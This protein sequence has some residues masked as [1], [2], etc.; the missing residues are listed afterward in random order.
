MANPF[1]SDTFQKTWKKAFIPSKAIES[2]NFIEGVNFYKSNFNLFYFNIGKNLTKGNSYIIRDFKDYKNKTLI[3]Y[4]VITGINNT[5]TTNNKIG[6]LKS[7]QYPGFLINIDHFNSVEEYLL[8]TF[9]KNTRMKMRKYTNRLNT[10]FNI[11]SKM[12]FG[13]IDKQEYDALFKHF[14]RLLEKRYSEKQITYNNMQTSEW[15]FYTDVAYPLILEKKASLFVIYDNNTPIAITYNYHTEDSLIDAITVFD[16]DYSKFNIGYVNNLKLINWCFENNIK[17]LDFSKGYFDYKKRMCT[18][19]Y[20]FEYHIIYDKSSIFSKIKAHSY[21]TFLEF[22]TYLRN[23]GFNS[24]FHEFTY[25]LKNNTPSKLSFD[26]EITELSNLPSNLILSKLDIKN[27]SE[28]EFL[29]RHINDFLYLVTK[30][31]KDI[32]LYKVN[33]MQHTYILESDTLIL[34]LKVEKP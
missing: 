2:F 28:Y 25:R 16:I 27:D 10:C 21:H 7:N 24:K 9:S 8:K 17:T 5:N 4:D 14:M 26:A 13:A 15:N 31:Y 33:D 34:Q 18:S 32:E 30:T 11:S 1:S 3:V 29:K 22:K 23:K 12:F 6:I 20:H 19:E